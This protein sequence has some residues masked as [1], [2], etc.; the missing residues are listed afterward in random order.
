M[1]RVRI[2]YKDFYKGFVGCHE[3]NGIFDT[4]DEAKEHVDFI[5]DSLPVYAYLDSVRIV[6]LDTCLDVDLEV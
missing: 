6:N 3:L 5:S 4:L 2:C 1:F